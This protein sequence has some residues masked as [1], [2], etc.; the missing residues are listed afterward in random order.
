MILKFNKKGKETIWVIQLT[1]KKIE[2][3]M[4]FFCEVSKNGIV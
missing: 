1:I 3:Q 2:I 4:K